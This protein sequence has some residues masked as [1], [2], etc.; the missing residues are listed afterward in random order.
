[1]APFTDLSTLDSTQ[2]LHAIAKELRKARA[3]CQAAGEKRHQ[4]ALEAVDFD[5]S[6]LTR[7]K[8]LIDS[9]RADAAQ[10]KKIREEAKRR[11]HDDRKFQ[12]HLLE[13]IEPIQTAARRYFDAE[14]EVLSKGYLIGSDLAALKLEELLA[15]AEA[16]LARLIPAE[17]SVGPQDALPGIKPGGRVSD[18]AGAIGKARSRSEN[19]G[20]SGATEDALVDK[21]RRDLTALAGFRR[22]IAWAAEQAFPWRSGKSAAARKAF[23][24]PKDGPLEA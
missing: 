16:I 14:S 4:A 15:K 12:T 11:R 22:Q 8:A 24:L 6:L 3:V 17:G 5:Q 2:L 23:G 18:L 9:L 10:C 13:A 19:S 7:A 20:A 21:L 1:M